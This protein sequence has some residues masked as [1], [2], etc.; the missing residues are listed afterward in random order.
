MGQQEVLV[1]TLGPNLLQQP[2]ERREV[3]AKGVHKDGAVA[4][5]PGDLDVE[6]RDI[7]DME[8]LLRPAHLIPLPKRPLRHMDPA[9]RLHGEEKHQLK[10]GDLSPDFF[11]F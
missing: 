3:S 5:A 2:L 11:T 1:P 8:R 10:G 9:K 6:V 7:P 4:V